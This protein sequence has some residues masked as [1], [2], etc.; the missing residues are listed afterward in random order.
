MIGTPASISASEPPQTVA[1]DEDPFDSRMSDTSRMAYGNSVSGGSKL[2]QRAFCERAVADFTASG[3]A[4]ELHFADAER[5]EIV[6]QHEAL[7]LILLKE[8]IESLHV[9]LGAEGQCRQSLRFAAGKK[10][11]AVDARQQVRLRR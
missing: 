11:R 10:R 1:I 7:E 4:Q 5:R 8:Q 9:F 6:V 2:L 3:A